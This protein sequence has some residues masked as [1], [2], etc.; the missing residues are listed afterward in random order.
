MI[1][2]PSVFTL[3]AIGETAQ[4][5]GALLDESG[6]TIA[7]A[8]ITWSSSN[9]AVA[10][11]NNTGLVTAHGNGT[12][13][14]TARSGQKAAS[15]SVT[16]VQEAGS[17]TVTPDIVNLVSIGESRQLSISAVD[18][19]GQKI[20]DPE[21]TW[22]SSD[23]AVATVTEK[24]L[25]TATGNGTA[26]ITAKSGKGSAKV[27]VTVAQRYH[28]IVLEPHSTHL[29][30][31][32]QTVQLTAEVQDANNRAV[33]DA[34]VTWASSDTAVATVTE[35]GLVTAWHRGTTE[36]TAASGGVSQ[37]LTVTVTFS[38]PDREALIAFYHATGGPDW[39]EQTNWLSDEPLHDW[40]GVTTDADA[41]VTR[42]VLVFNG[43]RGRL[44]PVLVEAAYRR[45]DL[46]ER[47]RHLMQD[48][49][50]YLAAS[51][52]AS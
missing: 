5:S 21:V 14:I 2:T 29:T 11:V 17:I 23:A 40:H 36:I 33:T 3:T 27:T 13:R 24:G 26:V 16:V 45:T 41:R 4:L 43:L 18:A 39:E 20:S 25:V 15:A 46:F 49:S 52:V 32:G 51:G 12:A 9:A 30:A 1:V 37:S 31:A 50:D 22:S 34:Q 42:L 44:P 48:W 6:G 28:R 10:S 19:N 38:S 7:G 8:P 35:S 47:R